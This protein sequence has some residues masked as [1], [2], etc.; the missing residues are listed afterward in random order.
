M[1]SYQIDDSSS[2]PINSSMET[3][4]ESLINRGSLLQPDQTSDPIIKFG[5]WWQLLL[6]GQFLSIMIMG[7]GVFS[8]LLA[9]RGV[10]IPTSQSFINYLCLS[11][12]G[13]E[14]A[15]R[16]R[17][18]KDLQVAWW[19]YA[20]VAFVDV[21][22]NAFVVRAYQYTTI[23]SVQL[24]DCFTIPCVMLLSYF[25]MHTRY[26]IKHV[27]GGLLCLTGLTLLVFSDILGERYSNESSNQ[28]LGD[29]LVLVGCVFYAMSN[30]A[31][32]SLVKRF[33]VVE[34]LGMLGLF[35][36]LVSGVQMA[37]MERSGLQAIDWRD[38]VTWCYL[39]SF[40]VCLT[41]LY[42]LTPLLLQK[43]QFSVVYLNLSFLTSDFWSILVAVLLFH[44]T[45]LYLYF[46]AFTII[47]VG[48]VLYNVAGF[49][50][51]HC[52]VFSLFQPTSSVFSCCVS[53]EG[54]EDS[55]PI[56]VQ[57]APSVATH[58]DLSRKSN[59]LVPGR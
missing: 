25:V 52:L 45:L 49:S 44:S 30:V 8:Q 16:K 21:E 53:T 40:S 48:L 22:G 14:I 19:K 13:F 24:L 10:D 56:P 33:D 35:G 41:V 31:Q 5:K 46:I 37:I 59:E 26:N 6:A 17:D 42:V 23:T 38:G 12:F 15:R 18:G 2:E 1:I 7:T 20:L 28:L 55:D 58:D 36:S 29:V 32:E 34:F 54:S 11:L 9:M 47:V 39:I 51:V 50:S 43:P 57:H 3:D 27:V 4:L